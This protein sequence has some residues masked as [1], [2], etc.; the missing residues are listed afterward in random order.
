MVSKLGVG[1]R[2]FVLDQT[3]TQENIGGSRDFWY[4]VQIPGGQRGWMFGAYTAPFDPAQPGDS[5]LCV[6]QQRLEAGGLDFLD[7]QDLCLFLR[8]E[9]A[10]LKDP[11]LAA[12]LELQSY[13]ALRKSLEA[14][15]FRQ[16]GRSP[17]REWLESET[18]RIIYNSP[19]G[20]WIIHSAALWDLQKCYSSLPIAEEIAWEAATN[21]LAGESE[22]YLPGYLYRL[23]SME[24]R[25]LELYPRGAHAGQAMESV[26]HELCRINRDMGLTVSGC[27]PADA[28]DGWMPIDSIE[29]Q[30]LPTIRKDLASL[31]AAV[32]AASGPLR[33]DVLRVLDRLAE[34]IPKPSDSQ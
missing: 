1:S 19:A 31:R 11:S 15:P 33:D 13:R 34:G 9:A 12:E 23:N 20:A 30:D 2:L 26:F 21:Q 18:L 5:L 10:N 28:F 4:R 27:P 7:Y 29:P 8:R 14:V 6:A 22:G 16:S 24:G 25:Y 3:K 17:Y 32:A